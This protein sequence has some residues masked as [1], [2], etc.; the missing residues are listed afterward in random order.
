[1]AANKELQAGLKAI[2]E[3][4]HLPGDGRMKLSRL[5][6]RHLAWFDLAER[7]GMSW[8]DVARALA[9]S[10]IT[11]E[12]GRP[13]SVGT[14]SSTAWRQRAAEAEHTDGKNQV[15]RRP[16]T[17]SP[18]DHVKRPKS[19][20]PPRA[21][22]KSRKSQTGLQSGHQ[23][24]EGPPKTATNSKRSASQPAGKSENILAFMAR[25]HAV[26]RRSE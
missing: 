12:T 20:A 17:K 4:F 15:G 9:A 3:D 5:I 1:M 26:R 10:G 11:S 14:L 22:M 25:A 16:S 19:T 13:L 18:A 8:R 2:A 21:P 6:A 7:R 23:P 24:A